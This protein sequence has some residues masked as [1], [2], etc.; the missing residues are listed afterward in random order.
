MIKKEKTCHEVAKKIPNLASNIKGFHADFLLQTD[1]SLLLHNYH[2]KNITI[3]D[4]LSRLG[5][6]VKLQHIHDQ[7]KVK[8]ITVNR[9]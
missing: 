5:R 4:T 8:K 3:K 7:N 2:L 1:S 6:N 9:E